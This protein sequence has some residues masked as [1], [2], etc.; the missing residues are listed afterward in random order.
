MIRP[1]WPS[2]L[3]IGRLYD[4]A[5]AKQLASRE[6]RGFLRKVPDYADKAKLEKYIKE[7]P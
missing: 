2:H 7:N 1:V 4:A 6:F 3:L 5:G